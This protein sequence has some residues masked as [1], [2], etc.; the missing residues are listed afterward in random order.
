MCTSINYWRNPKPGLSL[1]I[2]M[3]LIIINMIINYSLGIFHINSCN[4]VAII[5][6][7]LHWYL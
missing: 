3:F 5:Y 2:D 7:G 6:I 4:K 1:Y